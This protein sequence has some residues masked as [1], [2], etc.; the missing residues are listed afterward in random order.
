M[1]VEDGKK[2]LLPMWRGELSYREW[3]RTLPEVYFYDQ[4]GAKFEDWESFSTLY[5]RHCAPG[6]VLPKESP[7]LMSNMLL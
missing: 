7:T 6:I 5:Q 3:F 4:K 2:R 1:N